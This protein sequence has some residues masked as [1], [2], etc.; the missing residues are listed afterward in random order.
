MPSEPTL[1]AQQSKLLTAW[2]DIVGDR[3]PQESF[4]KLIGR[5]AR[6]QLGKPYKD[7]ATGP[8]PEV[9]RVTLESFDC[10]TFVE[11]TL[12]LARCIW[13]G[14][15]NTSCFLKE[16]TTMRYRGG[17]V[18]DFASRLH[19]FSDWLLTNSDKR[20]VT[21]L[22]QKLGGTIIAQEFSFMSKNRRR[23]PALRDETTLAKII[24][25]QVALGNQ[26]HVIIERQAIRKI[27]SRLQ[28]GD[29]VALAT[30]KPGLLVSHAGFVDR[31][32][33]GMPRL[34][35]ASSHHKRVLLTKQD[36]ADYV[37]RR[38]DRRGVIL[39]RPLEPT[40]PVQSAI[41]D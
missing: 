15:R 14:Q 37:S 11:S 13:Q 38:P 25:G 40:T 20:Y 4:G 8:G 28:D 22:T 23:Y 31:S 12:A 39:A 19:Y 24:A 3:R 10:V 32:V 5:T 26:Q 9:L 21:P 27:E 17:K 29:L 18:E 41:R 16:V 2:Y 35:H 6:V 34:L 36:L 30:H 33:D 7:A 1:D